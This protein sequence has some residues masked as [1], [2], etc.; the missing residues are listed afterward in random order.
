MFIVQNSKGATGHRIENRPS[1]QPSLHLLTG[2]NHCQVP[3]G[4]LQTLSIVILLIF[5]LV[6][7]WW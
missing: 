2:E 7:A 1:S 5:S 4:P 6:C 3:Q